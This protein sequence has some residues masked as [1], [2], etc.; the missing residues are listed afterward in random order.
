MLHVIAIVTTQPG[1]R[2][3]VLAEFT[4]V[5]VTVR[6]EAGC[7]RYVPVV[8]AEDARAS[9]AKLGPDRFMV[10]EA[11]ESAGALAAH[12]AAAH[13]AAYSA[14]VKD[15]LAGVAVHELDEV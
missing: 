15:M 4:K 3:A 1:Q 5:A 6:E 12:A 7:I 14:K 8:D 9:A 10:I 2:D 13:M 11:W